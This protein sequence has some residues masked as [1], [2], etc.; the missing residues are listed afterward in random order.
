M[1]VRCVKKKTTMM[2]T[3][4]TVDMAISGPQA[5]SC[6][7]WNCCSAN[8]SE[9]PRHPADHIGAYGIDCAR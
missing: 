4:I 2:G 5:L 9:E 8:A 1:N 6:W 3:V 7:L